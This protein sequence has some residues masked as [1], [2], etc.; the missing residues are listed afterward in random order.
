[1]RARSCAIDSHAGLVKNFEY[2]LSIGEPL[3]V[4]K[5]VTKTDFMVLVL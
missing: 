4:V 1:M 3:N 2:L 5:E